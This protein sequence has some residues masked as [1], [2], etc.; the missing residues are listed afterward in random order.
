MRRL[1]DQIKFD[2]TDTIIGASDA[3]DKGPHSAEVVR[4]LAD[5]GCQ[6]RQVRG[7]HEMKF[8]RFVKAYRKDSSKAMERRGSRDMERTMNGLRESDLEWLAS[9]ATWADVKGH[10]AIVVHAGIEP[11]M[12][13]LPEQFPEDKKKLESCSAL[14]YTRFVKNG[15]MV[16]LGEEDP[17]CQFWAD[18]YDGRYG[19]VYYGHQPFMQ[20]DPRISEHAVGLDLGGVMGGQL[21]A[22]I[23]YEDRVEFDKV[24]CQEYVSPK[25]AYGDE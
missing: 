17:E 3:V 12:K 10:N 7:N 25:A 11:A 16:K 1:L 5:L 14:W 2:S 18:V 19:T 23:F 15:R 6:V 22:A 8:L 21:A 24:A 4:F 9:G 13:R 20:A